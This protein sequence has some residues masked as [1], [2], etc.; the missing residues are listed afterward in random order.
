MPCQALE[1]SWSSQGPEGDA[2]SGPKGGCDEGECA[3][4]GALGPGSEGS[5]SEAWGA[6]VC[7]GVP[8]RGL[9]LACGE[10]RGLW[11]GEGRV[12]YQA[13]PPLVKAS[14]GVSG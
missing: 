8:V 7:W 12:E 14:M 2:D 6:A 10:G 9:L 3:T 1:L 13:L 5:R 4:A 11:S